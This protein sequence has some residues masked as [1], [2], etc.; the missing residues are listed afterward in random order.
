MKFTDLI[1]AATLLTLSS[2][3]QGQAERFRG[4]FNGADMLVFC[5]AANDDPI[6]DFERGICTGFIDGFAAGRHVG[7]TWHAFHHR[8]EKLDEVHGHLCVPSD[9][10][11][12]R[13]AQI[14]VRYM[15]QNSDRLKWN[16][17]VL[18]ESALREAF[19]CPQ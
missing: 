14:Y 13:I 9:I 5:K 2:M 16:A 4:G 15:E 7:D 1:L 3:A 17:G 18:L 12:S 8:E 6:K 10:S 11:R 19:P